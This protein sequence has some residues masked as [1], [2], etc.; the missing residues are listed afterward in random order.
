MDRFCVGF[1]GGRENPALNIPEVNTSTI[2][3]LEPGEEFLLGKTG[4]R[5]G[6]ERGE[7]EG[8]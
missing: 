2:Q 1:L 8:D 6:E 3:S 5:A 7:E 4:A